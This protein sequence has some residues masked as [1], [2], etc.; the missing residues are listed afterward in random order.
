MNQRTNFTTENLKE[1]RGSVMKGKPGKFFVKKE[2]LR[3][4]KSY[5]TFTE[6]Y[7][8]YIEVEKTGRK[9]NA[10]SMKKEVKLYLYKRDV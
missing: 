2:K 6:E 9:I 1:G 3:V 10:K 4:R 8:K 7:P 5:Y